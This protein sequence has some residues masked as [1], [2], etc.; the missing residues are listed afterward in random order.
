MLLLLC[1]RIRLQQF[2]VTA[3]DRFAAVT[4][5]LRLINVVRLLFDIVGSC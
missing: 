3:E 4:L 5:N 2:G 1:L